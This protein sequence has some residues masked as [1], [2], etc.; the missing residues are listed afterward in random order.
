MDRKIWRIVLLYTITNFLQKSTRLQNPPKYPDLNLTRAC[1]TDRN[2]DLISQQININS[3]IKSHQI[4]SETR[5][6]PQFIWKSLILFLRAW[7]QPALHMV[8]PMSVLDT[9]LDA[10]VSTLADTSGV[11]I[12][13]SWHAVACFHALG[14]SLWT[15]N[16]SLESHN[17]NN[18]H[19]IFY[20][21][22]DYKKRDEWVTRNLLID[23]FLYDISKLKY[24]VGC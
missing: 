10:R 20:F 24:N 7:E 6:L 18:E 2:H 19:A 15:M 21:S 9:T 23:N 16:V 1:I 14:V 22:T 3:P 12:G 17:W 8:C 5:S 11:S 4:P 13:G